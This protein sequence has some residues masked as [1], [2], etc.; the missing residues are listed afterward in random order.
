MDA[1][2]VEPRPDDLQSCVHRYTI[3]PRGG[4]GWIRTNVGV[5]PTS[6]AGKRIQPLCHHSVGSRGRIRTSTVG[7]KALRPTVSRLLNEGGHG[8]I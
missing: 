3:H 6:L 8:E 2:G 1:R 5:T 7:S 4:E